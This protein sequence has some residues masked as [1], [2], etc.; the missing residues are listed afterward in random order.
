MVSFLGVSWKSLIYMCIVSEFMAGG[1]LRTFLN[2]RQ[3]RNGLPKGDLCR[4]GFCRQKVKLAS[5]V[6]SALSFLHAQG[7]VHG[8][9]PPQ[10]ESRRSQ[11]ESAV[12]SKLFGARLSSQVGVH[13][14]SAELLEKVAAEHVRVHFSSSARDRHGQRRSSLPAETDSRITG[15][16]VHLGKACVALN[17][18]E[19]PSAARVMVV[20]HKL[21][22]TLDPLHA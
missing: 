16:V 21:L 4:R 18:S 22:Q 14:D 10:L 9:L 6:A 19:R 2:Q 7:L 1:D 8:A 12:D 15:V 20:L 5:Q 17:A 13:S 3:Y 11:D